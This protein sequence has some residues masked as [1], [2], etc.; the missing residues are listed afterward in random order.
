MHARPDPF[1]EMLRSIRLTGGVFLD[2]RFTAPW[3]VTANMSPGVQRFNWDLQSQPV[4]S[5]PGVVPLP[6][7]T[8]PVL[9]IVTVPTEPVPPSVP[10]T[11]T[12]PVESN[13]PLTMQVTFAGMT[14]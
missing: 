4:V 2:A 9:E 5:F 3:C 11:C 8:W 10:S 7:F 1:S 14:S 6:G 12:K 13:E